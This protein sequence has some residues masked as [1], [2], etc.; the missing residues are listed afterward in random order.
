MEL[1]EANRLV[2][3]AKSILQSLLHLEVSERKDVREAKEKS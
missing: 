1:K 3:N 2:D